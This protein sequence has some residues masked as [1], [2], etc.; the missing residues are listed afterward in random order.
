M[1]YYSCSIVSLQHIH[2]VLS[3]SDDENNVVVKNQEVKPK[4]IMKVL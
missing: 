3:K 4:K 1:V 2:T